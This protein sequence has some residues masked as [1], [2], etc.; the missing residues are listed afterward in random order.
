MK[1]GD[2]YAAAAGS[3]HADFSTET[4]ARYIIIFRL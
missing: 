3:T 4:G 2:G 1:A